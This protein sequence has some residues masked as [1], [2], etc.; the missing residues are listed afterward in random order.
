VEKLQSNHHHQQTNIQFFLQAGCPTNGVKA[1][2]GISADICGNIIQVT[3]IDSR[4]EK[5]S[6]NNPGHVVSE[7]D[8]TQDNNNCFKLNDDVP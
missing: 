8:V 3:L 2:K 5:R 1:L 4:T 6:S 7:S